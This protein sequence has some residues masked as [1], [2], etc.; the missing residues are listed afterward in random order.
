MLSRLC[1]VYDCFH[2]TKAKS[3]WLG[4][5]NIYHLAIYRKSFLILAPDLTNKNK[6][7]TTELWV[8]I[9]AILP[10]HK[11][12]VSGPWVTISIQDR[13]K[14]EKTFSCHGTFIQVECISQK[15]YRRLLLSHSPHLSHMANPEP[16]TEM[17]SNYCLSPVV[18]L[19]THLS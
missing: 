3:I 1:I 8:Y 12:A 7:K 19:R 17:G 9:P 2:I 5:Q 11:M 4:K 18:L 6:F 16:D 14:R 10:G 15:P 13:K